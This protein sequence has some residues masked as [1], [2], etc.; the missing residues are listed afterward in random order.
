MLILPRETGGKE[1]PPGGEVGGR[2]PGSPQPGRQPRQ[3]SLCLVGRPGRG[4]QRG[5][6]QPEAPGRHRSGAGRAARHARPPAHRVQVST[7]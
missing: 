4:G 6:Q 1:G 7:E 3:R 5:R 2:P